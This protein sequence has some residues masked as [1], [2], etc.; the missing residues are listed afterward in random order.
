MVFVSV[1]SVDSAIFD[2]R[3]EAWA[4]LSV[5]SDGPSAALVA[6]VEELGVEEAAAAVRDRVP[7]EGLPL[8]SEDLRR[9]DRAAQ[10]LEVTEHLGGRF[11]TPDDAEWPRERFSALTGA[12][13]DDV[14]PLGLWVLG[15]G[16][17]HSDR[18]MIAIAGSRA[19]TA[20]GEHVTS[21]IAGDLSAT[22]WT[23]V[24]TGSFG[25]AS[26]AHRAALAVGGATIA[27]TAASIDRAHPAAHERMFRDISEHGGLVVSEYP[28]THSVPSRHRSLAL[29]RLIAALSQASVVVE[30]GWRGG[31]R[32]I[33]TWASKLGRPA[34]AV[35]G[36]VTS[37]A[38]EGC[39]R[40]IREGH[41]ALVTN[42]ADVVAAIA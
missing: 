14:S 2:S 20:Y 17:L 32:G 8:G 39:H 29:N 34:L 16:S 9:G 27:V 26:A 35:P 28:P 33:L 38:S 31:S 40:A 21:E 37:A 22:G 15:T 23:V 11:V 7:V 3:R 25:I 12:D 13:G 1:P 30:T 10:F 42:S 6:L 5:V 4:F 41:A 24:S 36:P 18:G 19:S